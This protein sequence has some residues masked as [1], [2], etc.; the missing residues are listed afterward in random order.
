MKRSID[1]FAR[2]SLTHRTRIVNEVFSRGK[3]MY[4]KRYVV[5]AA[6]LLHVP[7][8]RKRVPPFPCVLVKLF[9]FQSCIRA[10]APA[11]TSAAAAAAAAADA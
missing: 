7:Q 3:G 8:H 9:C 11:S 4:V 10:R 1:V 2:K 6:V 5:V